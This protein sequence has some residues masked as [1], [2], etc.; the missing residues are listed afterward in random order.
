MFAVLCIVFSS[1]FIYC[2]F[3]EKFITEF[4]KINSSIYGMSWHLLPVE[5]QKKIPTM[6]AM[7]QRPVH[8]KGFFSIQCSHLYYQNVSN[9]KNIDDFVIIIGPLLDIVNIFLD[10]C[11]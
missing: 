11:Q 5:M 9:E 7:A 1:S 8:L 6:M 10:I 3:G 2:F 4:E